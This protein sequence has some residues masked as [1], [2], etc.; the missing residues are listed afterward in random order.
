MSTMR[1]GGWRSSGPQTWLRFLDAQVAV[2]T[3]TGEQLRGW[4][5]SVDPVS[6]SLVLVNFQESGSSVRVVLGHAVEDVQVLQAADEETAE[7]LQTT[8]LSTATVPLD[9]AELRA[10]RAAVRRW[11][12]Q[13]R[14]PVVEE[15]EE[16]R[17]AG[18]LTVLAP[19]GPDDCCSA[20]QIILDRI[21]RLIRI[22]PDPP[23]PW[24]ETHPDPTG[25]SWTTSRD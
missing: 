1:P 11:L 18:V 23:G 2:T 7:R 15:D 10:R 4:L 21:Q 5:L 14:V 8:F 3:V 6:A 25:S 17:V 19:Y 24:P 20:N 12:E 22:Q 13:N 16:L 9:P